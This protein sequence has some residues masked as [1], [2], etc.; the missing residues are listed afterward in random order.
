MAD[1]GKARTETGGSGELRRLA[2]PLV[3]LTGRF[4]RLVHWPILALTLLYFVSG[5]TVVGPDENAVVLR[6]GRIVGEGERAVRDSG[7]VFSFP[8]P[9]DEVVRVNV[10]RV[11]EVELFD[12]WR[13]LGSDDR[14]ARPRPTDSI[15]PELDGYALTGNRNIIQL[16]L[17]ARYQVEDIVAYAIEVDDPHVLMRDVVST[18]M[19]TVTGRKHIDA[20]IADDRG[21]ISGEAMRLAQRKLDELDAGMRLISLEVRRLDVPFQVLEAFNNVQGA[22]IEA[23]TKVYRADEYREQELPAARARAR[24]IVLE[25]RAYAARRVATAQGEASAFLEVL[26]E[27]YRN[28]EVVTERLFREAIENGL[29]SAGRRR[30]FPPPVGERYEGLRIEI[31]VRGEGS[32]GVALSPSPID[33]FESAMEEEFGGFDEEFPALDDDFGTDD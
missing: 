15:D 32:S 25:A 23:L 17:I 31:P 29:E 19:V 27:C 30:Y 4:L 9:I 14:P 26:A 7:L 5:I 13:G 11:H 21:E 18:A 3:A 33:P 1:L 28:P 20:L 24:E 2:K 10:K 16:D 12:L 6:F 22:L 8:A